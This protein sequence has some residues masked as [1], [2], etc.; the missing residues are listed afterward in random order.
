[1][2]HVRPIARP[3]SGSGKGACDAVEIVAGM[4]F[5]ISLLSVT[6]AWLFW[7]SGSLVPGALAAGLFF[8]AYRLLAIS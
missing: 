5:Y 2:T 6:S 1:M 7:R 4:L 3:G 8:A